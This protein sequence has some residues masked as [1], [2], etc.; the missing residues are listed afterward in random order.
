MN[1]TAKLLFVPLLALQISYFAFA[2]LHR[3]AHVDEGF[4]LLAS[5]L[6]AAHKSIYRDFFFQ[7]APLLPY[8]YAF[9][10]KCFG[11]S[12]TSARLLSAILTALLA[13]LIYA[14]VT[15]ETG[16]CLLGV[17]SMWLFAS[18]TLIFAF[19]VTAN[20]YAMTGLFIFSAYFL[21]TSATTRHSWAPL[22]TGVVLALAVD[23]RSYVVI[24]VPIFLWWFTRSHYS[25]TP[26]RSSAFFVSGIVVGLMPSMYFFIRDPRVFLFDNLGYHAMRTDA[27]LVGLWSQKAEVVFQLFFGNAI[28]G[29]LQWSLL[30]GFCFVLWAN[31][32][33]NCSLR[34][35][36]V[37][38]AALGVISLMPTPAFPQYFGLCIP[39]MVVCVV[40]GASKMTDG[41]I[42]A[43]P[44][45][46]RYVAI[47]WMVLIGIYA[48]SVARSAR[49]YRS[50]TDVPNP[51][52]DKRD[53]SLQ[54]ISD[55]THA[56]N[57]IAIPGE[58]VA[59]FWPG[60]I[61]ATKASPLPGLEDDEGLRVSERLTPELRRKYH[62]ASRKE[63]EASFA[64]HR[65]RIVIV[66]S[67]PEGS[68]LYIRRGAG[69]RTVLE[70]DGYILYRSFGGVFIYIWQ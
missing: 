27:G 9:W 60:D 4:Y 50:S 69:F 59:S 54:T 48:G 26:E 3:F 16:Q 66:R 52:A 17:V 68:E 29:G 64:N 28:T 62:I 49:I 47:G 21:A 30:V 10:M 15:L 53:W 58:V 34:F 13:S 45:S 57:D 5:R 46:A 8:V 18:T 2:A 42:S 39:F 1:R 32:H 70:K 67:A 19:Y 35:A 31:K 63:I 51:Y 56:I 20:P 22:A 7:Q 38:A 23:T 11:V 37:I 44:T 14:Y 25:G 43:K 41:L 6:V 61:F 55:V 65:P 40:C 24:L 36:A 33:L 12:W